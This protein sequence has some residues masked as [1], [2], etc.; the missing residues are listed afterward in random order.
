MYFPENANVAKIKYCNKMSKKTPATLTTKIMFV[1]EKAM[2]MEGRIARVGKRRWLTAS[3]N[4][5]LPIQ[6]LSGILVRSLRFFLRIMA[7]IGKLELT[8]KTGNRAR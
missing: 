8:L 4:G 7:L 6:C 1:V 5:L 2:T 3:G